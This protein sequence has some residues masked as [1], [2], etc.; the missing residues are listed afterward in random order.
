MR[1]AFNR[2]FYLV[3]VLFMVFLVVK[4]TIF[5]VYV[6]NHNQTALMKIKTVNP[7][8]YLKFDAFIKA[9]ETETEWKVYI[10]S[11]YRTAEEQARLKKQDA[12]NARA[13]QSKHN[14]AKAVDMVLYKN[15]FLWQS[16]VVKASS[17]ERWQ[18]TGVLGIAKRHQLVWGGTF[19]NYYDPVHFEID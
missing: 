14:F 7:Q 9:V 2:L 18:R 10:T 3:L 12:R 1:K 16:W 4:K 11:T 19:S 6:A 13:G 8:Y 15:T 17:K 5:S